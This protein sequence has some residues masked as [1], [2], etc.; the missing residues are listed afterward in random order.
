MAQLTLKNYQRAALD[1]LGAFLRTARVRGA[2][3]AFEDSGYGY[4]SEPFGE[5]PCV[6]LRIPTGGGKTLLASHAVVRI[7]KEWTGSDAPTVLWLTPS[8]TIR[9]Q[10][11]TALQTPGHP[12]RAALEDAYGQAF[13]I[14]D[15]AGVSTISPQDFGHQAVV[16]VATIQSFRV[17]NPD[18]RNVYAFSESFEPHFRGMP[19]ERLA[20]LNDI[21]DAVVTAEDATTPDSPLKGHVGRPKFSLSNWLALQQPIVIVDEAHNAQTERSFEALK[22]LNPAMILELTATPVPRRTNVLYHVSAQ[23]LQS[24]NMV[25]LPIVLM[26]HTQGWDAAVFDAV[27]TQ[28]K[29][30]AEAQKESDYIRPIVLF[31]AQNAT[32]PVNVE[33]LRKHLIDELHIPAAHVA[34]ATGEKRELEDVRLEAPDCPIRFIITVQALREGWDCPFAYVLCSV[35]PVRSATAVEQLLGR[36]LRMPYARRRQEDSLNRAYAHVSETR[37]G[38]AAAALADRLIQGMG[39]EPLD[40]ASMIAPQLPLPGTDPGPL[41]SAASL[42]ELTVETPA[43]VS[44][45]EAENLRVEATD[46]GSRIVVSGHVSESLAEELKAT[47]RSETKKE[48]LERRI[49]QHNAIVAAQTAPV[50]RGEKFKPVPYLCYRTQG[51]LHLVEREAVL[52]EVDLD[53]LAERVS[54]PGFQ[55]VEQARAFELYLDG[56]MVKVGSGNAAQLELGN[57]SSDLTQEDLVRWLDREVR[58]SDIPQAHL[59]AFLKAV[60]SH[61]AHEQRIPLSSLARVRHVLA[62]RVSLRIDELRTAAA[63]KQFKQL[64]LDNGWDLSAEAA[65]SFEFRPGVYAVPVT[66]RYRGKWRFD[67]HFYPVL[68]KLRDGTEEFKCAV[69][70]DSHPKIKHWVRNLERDVEGSFWL[71]TSHGKFFPDFVCELVDGRILV[72]EYKGAHLQNVPK[73]IEKDQI[74][75]LWSE[76][77]AGRCLF[78]MAFAIDERDLD[79]R[80]QMDKIMAER[81]A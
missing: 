50:S 41:F 61:L 6:C 25:K 22:R 65:R 30:E 78:L 55:I 13:Q 1:E 36:I 29:L 63:E 79:V 48:E 42:P 81:N 71:P 15:L 2:K 19:P 8:E 69:T 3:A 44:L 54:L 73:E 64:V 62:Q 10:T 31:Q 49:E 12:Y 37:F 56:A 26:E 43:K 9:A 59:R 28:R 33:A 70:I 47:Q 4:R 58:Q 57:F 39:F 46:R 80:G 60:V 14:C 17:E 75:R 45:S 18:Q 11:L 24:E 74:G 23:E 20:I 16:A 38:E 51:E 52:E 7:A 53:L 72:I 40:V 21:P 35:Q 76:K 77:S 5:I 34:V 68:A 27:Q 66:D 67:K 32:Q